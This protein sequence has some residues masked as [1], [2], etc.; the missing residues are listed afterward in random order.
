MNRRIERLRKRY[1]ASDRKVEIERA[2]II[3]DAYKIRD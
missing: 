1:V 2:V 3:T